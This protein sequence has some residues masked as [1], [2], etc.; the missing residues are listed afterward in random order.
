MSDAVYLGIDLGTQSVRVMAVNQDGIVLGAATQRLMSQRDGVRHEQDPEAWWSA[1]AIGLREV[2][3]RLESNA[4]I[5]GVAVDATSGTILLM[6]A[7]AR[8]LTRAL[9]YD[10]GRATLEAVKVNEAGEALWRQMSYRMQPS[11]A[12]PKLLWLLRHVDIPA[13]ARL[14]HQNDFLNARLAGRL[15]PTDSSHALKTGYDLIRSQWQE[16]ILDALQVPLSLMPEVVAPGTKIG[17]VGA[18]AAELT[19]V[20]IGVPIFAGMTDGCAAQI[21]SGATEAGSW[22]TVI[23][24]TLVVKGVTRDLLS[25]PAGVVYSHRSMDGC[26]LPGGASSVGAS[27]IVREFGNADLDALN[28]AAFGAPPSAVVVYPLASKGERF[29]FATPE[30]EGFT[31]G[32]AASVEERY[33]SVL[34]GIA[35]IERLSFDLL[36][37]LGAPMGGRF[38]ISGGAVKSEALNQIRANMLE[39]ELSVPEV[40]EGAFG[41]A[42]LVSAAQSSLGEA[43]GRMVRIQ[44]TITPERPFAEYAE[45]YKDLVDELYSRGWLP[46]IL[47]ST[48]FAEVCARTNLASEKCLNSAR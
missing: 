39:R 25:D 27:A 6:D 40:T 30:A 5:R 32:N 36:R 46:G 20:P 47:R 38:S 4:Q 26:W 18:I 31:L 9:M 10:D 1:T 42:V 17:E 16:T 2:M 11:W 7:E 33:I 23:G 48:A 3:G 21:A 15:L 28:H 43:T 29:P 37:N 41:M 8:P 19:G 13:G 35:M 22:N 44:R 14:A 12:L 45:Q 34:Q 24:T